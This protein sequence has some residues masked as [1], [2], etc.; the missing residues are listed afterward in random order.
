MARIVHYTPCIPVLCAL[1]AFDVELYIY[2]LITG[3]ASPHEIIHNPMW[4]TN[5][6]TINKS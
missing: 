5:V 2:Y 4:F 6:V 3:Y 1:Y